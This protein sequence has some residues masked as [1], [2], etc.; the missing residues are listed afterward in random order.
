MTFTLLVGIVWCLE[1][2]GLRFDTGQDRLVTALTA[3]EFLSSLDD[4]C[5]ESSSYRNRRVISSAG[6]MNG[7]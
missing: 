2:W 7:C 6:P 5:S 3:D 1:H 4:L